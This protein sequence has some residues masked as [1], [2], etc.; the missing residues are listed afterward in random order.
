MNKITQSLL[1]AVLLVWCTTACDDGIID[2]D[3]GALPEVDFIFQVQTADPKTVSFASS[4]RN[5]NTIVWDFGDGSKSLS[6]STNH[7]Y[8]QNGVYQVSL[9]A[10]NVAGINTITKEITIDGPDLPVADFS[11]SFDNVATL[12][13]VNLEN[14]SQ[15]VDDVEWDFGDGNV[16][17]DPDLSSY[18]YTTSG[19]YSIRLTVNSDDERL[20]EVDRTDT[21]RITISV[22]DPNL[23]LGISEKTWAFDLG[24]TER[25]FDNGTQS[26][27]SYYVVEA[28]ELK[29]DVPILSCTEDDRY[30]FS[31]N[32]DYLNENNGDG[33]LLD[34]GG[35][36]GDVEAPGVTE[37]LIS[38]T[39]NSDFE[40]V[41][42]NSYLGD[43][44]LGSFYAIESITETELLVSVQTI[45]P[46]SGIPRTIFMLF[47]P[48]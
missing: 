41:L 16:S 32:G 34:L 43:S 1:F 17:T 15:N 2:P 30:T 5:A 11:V 33:R 7:T 35:Q 38:R 48:I 22:L 12:L 21:K 3:P 28:D 36:C 42:A 8:D 25:S 44:E 23:L 26:V 29:F 6:N 45:S 18:T 31:Q 20:D 37:W 24:L 39:S 9:T 4:A 10:S 13:Q 47:K 46:V 40:L 14:L 27:T 19:M